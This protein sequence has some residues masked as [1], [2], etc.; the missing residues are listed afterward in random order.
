[1]S[2]EA[3]LLNPAGGTLTFPA[4]TVRLATEE[5]KGKYR[6]GGLHQWKIQESGYGIVGMITNHGYLDNPT[7]RGTRLWLQLTGVQGEV[8]WFLQVPYLYRAS[9]NIIFSS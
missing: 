1:M 5:F 3:K 4:E 7:L 6:A 2:L 9:L 8:L